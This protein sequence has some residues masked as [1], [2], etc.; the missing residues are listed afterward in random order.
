VVLVHGFAGSVLAPPLV[1][2]AEALHAQGF[3]VLSYDSRGHGASGGLCTLGDLESLD[4]AA[5]VASV[6]PAAGRDLPV[7]VVG[8]SMGAI[9][10]LRYAASA[11]RPPTDGLAGVVAVSCP[12]RWRVPRTFRG[13]LSALLTQTSI[14]RQFAKRRLGANVSGRWRGP[15]TPA[16]LA[17]RIGLPV[18]F[19]HGEDDRFIRRAD[20]IELYRQGGGPRVLDIVPGVGHGFDALGA[21]AVTAAVQ[22]VLVAHAGAGQPRQAAR[23]VA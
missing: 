21:P 22:W 10:A 9:A 11:D 1:R 20:A 17:K 6:G 16:V 4:V 8:A 13:A 18:A 23:V 19:L 2:Q 5:A 7:V 15:E 3:E 12:S 14:G